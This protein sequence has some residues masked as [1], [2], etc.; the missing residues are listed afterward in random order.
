[1]VSAA[2][3]AAAT[4]GKQAVSHQPSAISQRRVPEDAALLL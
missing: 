1:V 4:A 2:A 3:A